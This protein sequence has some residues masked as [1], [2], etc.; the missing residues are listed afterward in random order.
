MIDHSVS[1]AGVLVGVDGSPATHGAVAWAANEAAR[2]H[3]PL[4]LVQVLPPSE[5]PHDEMRSPSGR[6]H[7]LLDQARHV[8]HREAPDLPVHLSVVD[9]VVGPALVATAAQARLLVL[10]A[11]PSGGVADAGVGRT[12]AHAMGH[13]ACPV[14]VVP[15][16]W[17]PGADEAMSGVVVGVDGSVESEGAVAFGAD[18]ADRTGSSLTVVTVAARSGGET[19]EDARRHL[20]EGV[21][22][23]AGAHPDIPLREV[24]RRGQV[25]EELLA[26]A[27]AGAALLAVGSRGRGA[28]SGVLLG[29]TSQRVVHAAPCPVAVLS[30]RA[31]EAWAHPEHSEAGEAS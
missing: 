20:A 29:S 22:G 16:R 21:A 8:A 9:G 13:A 24:V 31:A 4:D 10:G 14:V 2:R 6:A 18:V 1:P 25:A 26:E 5:R 27:R 19:E 15:A 3:L 23:I 17:E 30:P 12:V 28:V 7:A 11:R